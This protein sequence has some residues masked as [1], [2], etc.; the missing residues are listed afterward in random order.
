[1]MYLF[2]TGLVSALDDLVGVTIRSLKAA[3][4]F[5][6]TI[7]V[8]TSDVSSIYSNVLKRILLKLG[9]PLNSSE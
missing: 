5:H 6:D 9:K 8:F 4:L 3:N 7:I 2:I 1:M